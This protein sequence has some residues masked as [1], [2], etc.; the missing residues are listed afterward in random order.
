MT[1]KTIYDKG[2]WQVVGEGFT[3]DSCAIHSD[4]FD[5]DV[6]LTLNGDF[7]DAQTKRAYAEGLVATL[8]AGIA[9]RKIE[10]IIS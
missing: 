5:H 3:S 8:R 9:A 7:G 6:L 10:T 1:D 4:D 2:P